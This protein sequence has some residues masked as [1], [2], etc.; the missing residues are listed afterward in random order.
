MAAIYELHGRVATLSEFGLNLYSGCAVGCRY[1]QFPWLHRMTLEKWTT[2]A[3]PRK[4]I[5]FELERDAKRMEGDPRE[6]MISPGPDPYQSEEAAQ[7]T[8]KALLILEQYH[9]RV[10]VAT[11]CGPRSVRDF[12]I[13]RA[14][15]GDMPR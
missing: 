2:V 11:L 1:C 5:L 6:I 13:L 9:L 8:R 10:Q 15:A 12:D 3:Q 14:I 7:L 4:N